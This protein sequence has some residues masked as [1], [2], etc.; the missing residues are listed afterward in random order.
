MQLYMDCAVEV[1]ITV[2]VEE[3]A[4]RRRHDS[5][6]HYLENVCSLALFSVRMCNEWSSVACNKPEWL[7]FCKKEQHTA[8]CN[9]D[10]L[11]P[12]VCS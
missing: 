6:L 3:S 5:E 4:R 7:V 11:W 12:Q 2:T 9:S 10:S 8:S 1:S